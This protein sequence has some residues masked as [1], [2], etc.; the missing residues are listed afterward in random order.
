MNVFLIE[1]PIKKF[2]VASRPLQELS[3][4]PPESPVRGL[5]VCGHRRAPMSYS[6]LDRLIFLGSFVLVLNW[7]VRVCNAL[8]NFV[9]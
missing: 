6:N 5:R 4:T 2:I 9:F 1:V 8:L 3:Q 7:S